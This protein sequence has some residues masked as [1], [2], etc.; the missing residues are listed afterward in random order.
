MAANTTLVP[1]YS[2]MSTA[3]IMGK[4]PATLMTLTG[5][6]KV[7]QTLTKS[8]AHQFADFPHWQ[9]F[10]GEFTQYFEKES[11]VRLE[12]Y[13]FIHCRS[14]LS[15]CTSTFSSQTTISESKRSLKMLLLLCTVVCLSNSWKRNT[16]F[17]FIVRCINF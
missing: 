4:L 12:L 15:A 10:V 1:A 9:Y 5:M 17:S 6:I 7:T 13:S 8:K 11:R 2:T 14:L 3:D 16:V